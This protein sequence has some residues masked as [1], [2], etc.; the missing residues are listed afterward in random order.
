MTTSI[1]NCGRER[2]P[3]KKKFL[4]KIKCSELP[5]RL[6]RPLGRPAPRL[7]PASPPPPPPPSPFQAPP[8]PLHDLGPLFLRGSLTRAPWRARRAA[9][10]DG[11]GGGG[12]GAVGGG[13]AGPASAGAAGA[14]A[15]STRPH[16]P[17]ATR[18]SSRSSWSNSRAGVYLTASAGTAW[19]T[20]TPSQ[21][22]KT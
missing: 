18:S 8:P 3:Q 4:V 14:A 13:G 19:P 17:R 10:A 7:P 12:T 2:I 21:L 11:G 1:R 6:L 9:M 16:C 15:P 20:W 5:E 22:T